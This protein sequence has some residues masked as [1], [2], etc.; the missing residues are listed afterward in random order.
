MRGHSA[1]D[2]P[3]VSEDGCNAIGIVGRFESATGDD[4]VDKF[5]GQLGVIR[6]LAKGTVVHQPAK[7]RLHRAGHVLLAFLRGKSFH[8]KAKGVAQ[9]LAYQAS[10]ELI[11]VRT[12]HWGAAVERQRVFSL[13]DVRKSSNPSRVTPL[14]VL[15]PPLRYETRYRKKPPALKVSPYSMT[16]LPP[17]NGFSLQTGI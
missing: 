4:T 2:D 3:T 5:P 16:R 6:V 1:P 10:G 11:G 8:K 12:M 15:A 7:P 17:Q 9:A 13:E 14:W